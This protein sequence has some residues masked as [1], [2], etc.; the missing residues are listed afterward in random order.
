MKRE[1]LVFAVVVIGLPV[2]FFFYCAVLGCVMAIRDAYLYH[3]KK[4]NR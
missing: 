3:V 2:A 4:V 1:A